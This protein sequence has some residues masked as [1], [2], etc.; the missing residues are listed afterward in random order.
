MTLP[1]PRLQG[2]AW[3]LK[4]VTLLG[5][6]VGRMGAA[7]R[8]G[9]RFERP[10]SQIDSAGLTKPEAGTKASQ[11]YERFG[12]WTTIPRAITCWALFVDN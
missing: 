2:W 12:Y 9:A 8:N 10:D 1:T 6:V 4:W 3:R 5:M 11:I 7:P